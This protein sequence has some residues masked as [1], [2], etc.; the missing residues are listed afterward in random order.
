MAVDDERAA[1]E[2]N[3]HLVDTLVAGGSIRSPHVEAAFRAVLRHQFLPDTPLEEA[4]STKAI[5]TRRRRDGSPASSSSDPRIMAR[6]LEQLDVRPGHAVLEI[7]AG[8]GYNAALLGSITGPTGCVTTV[9][10]DPVV[11]VAAEQNLRRAGFGDVTVVTADGWTGMASAGPFDRIEATVGVWDLAPAWTEDLRP[12]GV[13]TVPLWLQAGLQAS[14]AFD[15]T[16]VGLSSRSI[17]P[18]AF[19]RLQ[20]LGAGPEGYTPIGRWTANFDRRRPA[21]VL[22]LRRLLEQEPRSQAPPALP[23]GWFTG[24]ALM[25]PDA[26]TLSDWPAGATLSGLFDRAG[27]GL[28][29]V[30]TEHRSY[31]ARHLALH[32]FGDEAALTTLLRHIETTPAIALGALKIEALPRDAIPD[33]NHVL[34]HLTRPNTH[35]VITAPAAA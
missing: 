24:I 23:P 19:M 20:G 2:L 13:L 27:A 26:I 18:C 5:V 30:E 28:A 35:L 10:I 14:V 34:A 31:E 12:G 6:M 3:E 11:T 25:V 15:K 17:E 21:D 1:K 9:D 22:V 32:A 16:E 33:D 4:Y 8:T 7:G 29:V